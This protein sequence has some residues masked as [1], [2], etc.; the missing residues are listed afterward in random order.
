MLFSVHASHVWVYRWISIHAKSMLRLAPL[1][2]WWRNRYALMR[3]Q[4][5]CWVLG[6]M[7]WWGKGGVGQAC[8]PQGSWPRLMSVSMCRAVLTWCMQYVCVTIPPAVWP[9]LFVTDGYGIFIVCTNLC[10]F[11]THEEGSGTSLHRSWLEGT[12]KLSLAFPHQT[13]E[14]RVFGLEF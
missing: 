9:T 8:S 6:R 13:F 10:E 7:G 1:M 3:Q 14:P 12:E 2:F 4:S 11:R 5:L